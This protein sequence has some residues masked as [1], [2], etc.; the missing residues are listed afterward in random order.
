MKIKNLFNTL[1]ILFLAI[2]VFGVTPGFTADKKAYT[3][4]VAWVNWSP[5]YRCTQVFRPGGELQRMLF[6]RS[7]GRIRL[8][9]ISKMLPS[10]EVLPALM[11]GRTDMGEVMMPYYSGT[12]PYFV[13]QDVPGVLSNDPEDSR[14]E[15]MAVYKDEQFRKIWDKKHET[16]GL[17]HLFLAQGGSGN[18]ICSKK[19][20]NK[21]SDLKGLK[22]RVYGFIPTLGVN[23]LGGVAT[24]VP[25][26][27]IETALLTGTVDAVLT[28]PLLANA[29]GLAKL[30]PYMTFVPLSPTWL[31]TGVINLDK[32][33]S[34]PED[35]QNVMLGVSSEVEQMISMSNSAEII[36][37]L[38]SLKNAGAQIIYLNEKQQALAVERLKPIE[39]K[40][41]KISGDTGKKLL[42]RAKEVIADY[43]KFD[44]HL[45]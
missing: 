28:G 2:T 11:E 16:M 44:P 31:D 17:K 3:F 5:L 38:Q 7:D 35:L 15:E 39:E 40:W 36:M 24:S 43:R 22:V 10:K 27:E 19:P 42:N 34:M 37:A 25:L 12:Y 30:T 8:N 21:L 26:E 13:W 41:M 4:N 1:T 20:I 9:I 18:L 33:N 23:A 45:K 14:G 6:E 32:F 29:I